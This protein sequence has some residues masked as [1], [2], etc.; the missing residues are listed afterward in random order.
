MKRRVTSARKSAAG[1]KGGKATARRS[2][3]RK[4]KVA[5]RKKIAVAAATG[6][7]AAGAGAVVAAR[8]PGVISRVVDT[9]K[10]RA[11]SLGSTVGSYL[12]GSSSSNRD[13]E[14]N[15]GTSGF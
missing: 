10:D 7:A 13:D 12:P 11:S 3:A 1:K 15:G 2:P 8:N 9:V 4:A 6:A 14:G 5:R